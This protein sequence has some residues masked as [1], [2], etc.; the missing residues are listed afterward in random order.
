MSFGT[1][2]MRIDREQMRQRV[3]EIRKGDEFKKFIETNL[4]TGATGELDFT[5]VSEK[6]LEILADTNDFDDQEKSDFKESIKVAEVKKQVDNIILGELDKAAKGILESGSIQKDKVEKLDKAAKDREKAVNGAFVLLRPVKD[7]DARKEE[8]EKTIKAKPVDYWLEGLRKSLSQD[9]KVRVKTEKNVQ[10]AQD[11]ID[12]KDQQ[13]N[14]KKSAATLYD[15]LNETEYKL[16]SPVEL[17]DKVQ[18][19]TESFESSKKQYDQLKNFNELS[20]LIDH[21]GIVESPEV[22][23]AVLEKKRLKNDIDNLDKTDPNYQTKLRVLNIELQAHEKTL[24]NVD[25][26]F[27]YFQGNFRQEAKRLAAMFPDD[28][29]GKLMPSIENIEKVRGDYINYGQLH[30]IIQTLKLKTDDSKD[31]FVKINL[32]IQDNFYNHSTALA[33]AKLAV[34]DNSRKID[35]AKRYLSAL[36]EDQ[37]KGFPHDKKVEIESLIQELGLIRSDDEEKAV[38]MIEKIKTV[39]NKVASANFDETIAND[40]INSEEIKLKELEEIIQQK[41]DL[42]ATFERLKA[43]EAE[44]KNLQSEFDKNKVGHL[45]VSLVQEL[46]EKKKALEDEEKKARPETRLDNEARYR[47]V[48]HGSDN[49]YYWPDSTRG[50]AK[51]KPLLVQIYS[52]DPGAKDM[53][54]LQLT[55]EEIAEKEKMDKLEQTRKDFLTFLAKNKAYYTKINPAISA[56]QL[57][58]TVISPIIPPEPNAKGEL[59]PTFEYNKFTIEQILKTSASDFRVKLINFYE[60]SNIGA[61]KMYYEISDATT[62]KY[63]DYVNGLGYENIGKAQKLFQELFADQARTPGDFLSPFRS[64]VLNEDEFKVVLIETIRCLGK[65]SEAAIVKMAPEIKL[66]EIVDKK[67]NKTRYQE[68]CEGFQRLFERF[69]YYQMIQCPEIEAQE[70]LVVY[71]Y[72]QQIAGQFALYVLENKHVAGWEVKG[73]HRNGEKFA[74]EFKVYKAYYNEVAGFMSKKFHNLKPRQIDDYMRFLCENFEA[75]RRGDAIDALLQQ[76]NPGLDPIITREMYDVFLATTGVDKLKFI[77]KYLLSKATFD[78]IPLQVINFKEEDEEYEHPPQVK[79][80]V[81]RGEYAKL[82]RTLNRFFVMKDKKPFRPAADKE[83][84]ASR[85]IYTQASREYIK[86]ILRASFAPYDTNLPEVKV[87]MAQAVAGLLSEERRKLLQLE[88]QLQQPERWERMKTW[89]RRQSKLRTVAGVLLVTGAAGASIMG[90][91]VIGSGLLMTS[92]VMSGFG[93]SVLIDSIW[94]RMRNWRPDWLGGDL[95]P[96]NDEQVGSVSK[97]AVTREHVEDKTIS[98]LEDVGVLKKL[99]AHS[100]HITNHRSEPK[101]VSSQLMSNEKLFQFDGNTP[102]RQAS[103]VHLLNCYNRIVERGVLNRING[104]PTG[105]TTDKIIAEALCEAYGKDVPNGPIMNNREEALLIATEKRERSIRWSNIAKKV[106]ALIGGTV[107]GALGVSH[108]LDSIKNVTHVIPTPDAAGVG[109]AKSAAKGAAGNVTDATANGTGVKIPP[110]K[111][112]PNPADYG[113]ANQTGNVNIAPP[114]SNVS[115]TAPI[116][117]GWIDPLPD[118]NLSKSELVQQDYYYSMVDSIDGDRD[119]GVMQ[120]L[121]K[122]LGIS[123]EQVWGI[124]DIKKELQLAR[125]E[126]AGTSLDRV[127]VGDKFVFTPSLIQKLAVASGKSEILVTSLLQ[128]HLKHN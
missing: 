116:G 121:A 111:P 23:T 102:E 58:D 59:P 118:L 47:M 39:F 43:N 93:T 73:E 81:A 33:N 66:D 51:K 106:A 41:K 103:G 119:P 70:L 12:N 38:T 35:R 92:A 82:R 85:E 36:T 97:D 125:V 75:I 7:N 17:K 74:N 99:A 114:I 124:A 28:V 61:H 48:I 68:I 128:N 71:N 65:V 79:L 56:E 8:R 45:Y 49:K 88:M 50:G 24:L 10:E 2:N 90:A 25:T 94:D 98:G 72:D 77:Y 109:A 95:H 5:K 64:H 84:D 89:W 60:L 14:A 26:I 4:N 108:A 42:I 91:P 107:V 100:T 63:G 52:A 44:I 53:D 83:L 30:Q 16:A 76:K 110:P 126:G 18:E 54:K 6:I 1:N 80:D 20:R 101:R 27:A 13:P 32:N 62:I 19:L 127:F 112:F 34:K 46:E 37:L 69:K 3:E 57:A 96:L 22:T 122:R 21:E 105:Q 120:A 40:T 123:K 11:S 78:D 104:T 9:E 29:R 117:D 87:Q 31:E 115:D 113:I 55:P 86:N 15:K 67:I